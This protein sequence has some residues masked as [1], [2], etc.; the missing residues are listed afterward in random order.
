MVSALSIAAM[1][2]AV[3]VPIGLF[4]VLLVLAMTKLKAGFRQVAIGAG[5][6]LLFSF[7]LE[8]LV[9]RIVLV[10]VGPTAGF[11]SGNVFAFSLYGGLMAGIFEET[12]RFIAMKLFFKK[13]HEWKH[14]VAYG[15]GHGGLELLYFGVLIALTNLNNVIYSVMINVG[16][17]NQL[18]KLAPGH[19]SA[20][21]QVRQQ[22]I[23]LPASVYLTGSVERIDTLFVQLAL[24][25]L[26]LY[27]VAKRRY[28]FYLLAVLIHAAMDFSVAFT[29]KLGVNAWLIEGG[30]FLL[31]V[32]SVVFILQSKKLFENEKQENTRLN[33]FI[34]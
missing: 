27:A 1:C 24:S 22:L 25:L 28:L 18:E 17:Y 19:S 10:W 14:G 13:R 23:S 30:I 33:K 29:G 5:V 4:L 26:V 34:K 15:L 3:V 6:M 20:L 16:Q 31:A 12:G 9:N 2:F 32:A 21:E 11:F 8:G 7:I